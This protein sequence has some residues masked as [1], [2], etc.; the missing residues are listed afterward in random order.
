MTTV[1]FTNPRARFFDRNGAPLSEGRVYFYIAGTNTLKEVYTTALGDI[2]AMNPQPLDIEGFVVNDTGIHLGEGLYDIK[3][4]EKTGANTWAQYWTYPDVQ[5]GTVSGGT[6]IFSNVNVGTIQ[7]LRDLQGGTYGMAFVMGYYAIGDGGARQMYWN[8][9]STKAENGGTVIVPQG[10]PAIGR[11]EWIPTNGD[12]QVTPQLFG[13]LPSDGSLVIA[14]QIDSMINWCLTSQHKNIEFNLRGE[15][16]FNSSSTFS[17]DL[18]VTIASGIEFKNATGSA[19]VTFS[20]Q[21]LSIDGLT[22]LVGPALTGDYMDLNIQTIEPIDI[23]P[24][25]WG[26]ADDGSATSQFRLSRVIAGTGFNNRIVF[27]GEFKTSS[28]V[29][30]FS[31]HVVLF[32]EDSTLYNELTNMT[33]GN[34]SSESATPVLTGE[35][36]ELYF[37][38]GTCD[39]SLID[40][41]PSGIVNPDINDFIVLNTDNGVRNF[42]FIVDT[43]SYQFQHAC[44]SEAVAQA[45]LVKFIW[46]LK[47]GCNIST[48][49]NG[50]VD[51]G[52][53]IAGDYKVFNELSTQYSMRFFQD[54]KVQWF[55]AVPNDPTKG[56]VN[57]NAFITAISMNSNSNTDNNYYDTAFT[58][59]NLDGGSFYSEAIYVDNATHARAVANME[60]GRIRSI[61]LLAAEYAIDVA[62]GLTMDKM[63]VQ[64]DQDGNPVLNTREGLTQVTNSIFRNKWVVLS[65]TEDLIIENSEITLVNTGVTDLIAI[66]QTGGEL[67]RI[68]NSKLTRNYIST[69]GRTVVTSNATRSHVNH[70]TTVG[71]DLGG[72]GGGSITY[73]SLDRASIFV[74]NPLYISVTNN[75]IRTSDDMDAKIEFTSDLTAY[76]VDGIV[77]VDNSFEDGT[78]GA[79]DYYTAIDMT[80]TIGGASPITGYSTIKNNRFN[81]NYQYVA[82]TQIEDKILPLSGQNTWPVGVNTIQLDKSRAGLGENTGDSKTFI[83][84]S[85]P[86]DSFEQY[87]SG[88]NIYQDYSLSTLNGGAIDSWGNRGKTAPPVFVL[89]FT[90][91]GDVLNGFIF[92][93][94]NSSDLDTPSSITPTVYP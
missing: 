11:W 53:V 5:G 58:T 55:G 25:W 24:Q 65:C 18:N 51:F 48:N 4:E 2:P 56:L 79:R 86:T 68:Q 22:P 42:R 52:V 46:D 7:N 20:C 17:G 36:N 76:Q 27:S 81:R 37:P 73:N 74:K 54:Q 33:F 94:A 49:T 57:S 66:S 72:N 43:G 14:S 63:N 67:L 9:T 26:V 29:L 40:W 82:T 50:R 83:A 12:T 31:N 38:L 92:V 89:T 88:V 34:I 3:V 75:A 80:G 19:T 62:Y 69:T 30:D 41:A 64:I 32:K 47:E 13:G 6:T 35:F 85:R 93:T 84:I 23:Y 15:Y 70:N 87:W 28:G 77:C 44:D 71:F 90:V 59:L 8:A 61:D 1:N 21:S 16:W 10:N 91:T 39:A 45:S 60:N 78:T